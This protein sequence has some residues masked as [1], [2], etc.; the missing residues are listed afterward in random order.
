VVVAPIADGSDA[1]SGKC[2]KFRQ[3]PT[4]VVS[5]IN[6]SGNHR[7]NNYVRESVKNG[8]HKGLYGIFT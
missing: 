1:V 3:F 4:G 6:C 8:F 5:N 2:G 7:E